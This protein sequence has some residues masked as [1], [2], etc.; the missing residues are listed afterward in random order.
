MTVNVDIRRCERVA[1]FE[2]EQGPVRAD[3]VVQ[4]DNPTPIVPKR[5]RLVTRGIRGCQIG[6]I[7]EG[8]IPRSLR[9]GIFILVENVA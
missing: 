3:V 1:P 9:R 6:L 8:S 7:S 5:E 2:R 4:L